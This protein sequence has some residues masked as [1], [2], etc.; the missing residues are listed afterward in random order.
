MPFIKRFLCSSNSYFK[1][2]AF[3]FKCI[4][5]LFLFTNHTN[6]QGVNLS[7]LEKTWNSDI[8]LR[9]NYFKNVMKQLKKKDIEQIRIPV[10]LDH[11]INDKSEK[12]VNNFKRLVYKINKY[13]RRKDFTIIWA[14][15]NHD[16]THE[17]FNEKTKTIHRL[18]LSFMDFIKYDKSFTK[19]HFEIVN[20]PEL[21]PSEWNKVSRIII[22]EIRSVYPDVKVI[23]GSSNYNSIYELS[24]MKPLP[25]S[26]VIYSFHFYEPFI[27]THQ[28]TKWTGDENA[29][30]GIPFPYDSSQM[31]KLSLKARNTDGEINFKNYKYT[32]NLK[33]LVDKLHIVKT[34]KEKHNVKVWCTEYGVT[35]NADEKSRSTYLKKFRL[36][37]KYYG[38]KGFI[39]EFTG[40][41]GVKNLLFR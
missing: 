27:F 17:N 32:G 14:N 12:Q 29:T 35:K 31:P 8:N 37:L 33:A 13:A 39:W 5:I 36:A 26:N 18:W 22:E 10:D 20:E 41:F 9:F 16:L 28:G 1:I 4:V 3:C 11:F 40:T 21:Y 6:A 38:F 25:F 2:K 15:F 19:V 23:I 30:I 7:G 34:W 24:R